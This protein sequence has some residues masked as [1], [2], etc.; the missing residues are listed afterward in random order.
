MNYEIIAVRLY[1]YK[2]ISNENKI[3]KYADVPKQLPL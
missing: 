1:H 3:L 2:Q